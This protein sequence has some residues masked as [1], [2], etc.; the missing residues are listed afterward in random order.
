MGFR[1]GIPELWGQVAE[2]KATNGG[3]FKIRH[4]KGQNWKNTTI[5]KIGLNKGLEMKRLR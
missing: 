1:E 2:S 4:V 3:T 5:Y